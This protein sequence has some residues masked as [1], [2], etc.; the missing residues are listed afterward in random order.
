M[1]DDEPNQIKPKETNKSHSS[2]SLSSPQ[3]D[4]PCET[5]EETNLNSNKAKRIPC[6]GELN[7]CKYSDSRN[8]VDV[9]DGS[10]GQLK[11][12]DK[13]DRIDKTAKEQITNEPS[14]QIDQPPTRLQIRCNQ[15][16]CTLFAV[17]SKRKLIKGQ[18]F[19]PY[20]VDQSNEIKSKNN[21][22]AK[23]DSGETGLELDREPGKELNIEATGEHSPQENSEDASN[24]RFAIRAVNQTKSIQVQEPAGFWLK[25]IRTYSS[26]TASIQIQGKIAL[27]FFCFFWESKIFQVNGV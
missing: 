21:L 5:V 18:R 26:P 13:F 12:I 24:S 14:G 19:G 16:C 8:S 7:D 4:R 1:R 2:Y 10:N 25:L 3:A 23:T 15:N 22:K 17:F 9:Q 6:N 27:I 11:E 20:R